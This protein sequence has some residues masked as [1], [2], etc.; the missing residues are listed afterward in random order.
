MLNAKY[1]LTVSGT[2]KSTVTMEENRGPL[3][4]SVLI[5]RA[6]VDAPNGRYA[7]SHFLS[8]LLIHIV[9]KYECGQ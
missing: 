5:A 7:L 1:A 6:S 4:G 8:D 2:P 3:F 9:L